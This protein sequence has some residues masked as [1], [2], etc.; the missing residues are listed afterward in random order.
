M[1]VES[2]LA[3]RS[4]LRT[5]TTSHYHFFTNLIAIKSLGDENTW[6]R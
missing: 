4:K 1:I 3:E 2:D 5:T 6:K